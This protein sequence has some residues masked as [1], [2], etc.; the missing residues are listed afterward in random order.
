MAKALKIVA[1]TAMVISGDILFAVIMSGETERTAIKP[2][3][4]ETCR[5]VR[6]LMSG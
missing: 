2:L 5:S 3:S 6:F 4:N 1:S